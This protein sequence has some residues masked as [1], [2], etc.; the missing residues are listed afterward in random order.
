MVVCALQPNHFHTLGSL[1]SPQMLQDNIL[2]ILDFPGD[3]ERKAK[4]KDRFKEPCRFD[5]KVMWSL[6]ETRSFA[7]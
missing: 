3:R 4:K 6:S 2:K 1:M 5:V 7:L